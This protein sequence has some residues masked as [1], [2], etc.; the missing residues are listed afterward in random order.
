[1]ALFSEAPGA[2]KRVNLEETHK[3]ENLGD[4]DVGIKE[5]QRTLQE[6]HPP[7]TPTRA[8]SIGSALSR[9]VRRGISRNLDEAPKKRP[10]SADSPLSPQDKTPK[11]QIPRHGNS[12]S[13]ANSR[14]SW[15]PSSTGTTS[16]NRPNNPGQQVEPE[17]DE[18]RTT[19]QTHRGGEPT[20][21]LPP[22]MATPWL[23]TMRAA[24]GDQYPDAQGQ[25]LREDLYTTRSAE[26]AEKHGET[27]REANE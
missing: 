9:L 4:S 6:N 14:I 7:T 11:K 25:F 8:S 1:M 13:R 23:P 15:N 27:Q 24:A 16:T 10:S 12:R 21:E 22:A 17:V 18:R 2:S 3:T 19:A 5:Q 26:E 20:Y